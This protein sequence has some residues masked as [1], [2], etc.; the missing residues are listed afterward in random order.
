M[1][2]HFKN[3]ISVVSHIW[4]LLTSY[5][6]NC[7]FYKHNNVCLPFDKKNNNYN[8]QQQSFRVS[9]GVQRVGCLRLDKSTID[10]LL[11]SYKISPFLGL[12]VIIKP[13]HS[14]TLLNR[15]LWSSSQHAFLQFL[16]L[17]S[18]FFASAV[19]CLWGVL[20]YHIKNILLYSAKMSFFSP[21]NPQTWVSFFIKKFQAMGPFSNSH[22]VHIV[23]LK[24]L[25]LCVFA[26]KSL[27][28]GTYC[29][30]ITLKYGYGFSAVSGT[31]PTS[32]KFELL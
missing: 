10:F 22:N 15:R 8:S 21:K 25:N 23:N 9:E 4:T 12:W 26:A 18:P 5:F 13:T 6:D 19:Y 28:M 24:H 29:L 7:Q 14:M 30:K 2:L 17:I 1:P 32:Y 27:E 31:S 16:F 20:A 11:T 3:T